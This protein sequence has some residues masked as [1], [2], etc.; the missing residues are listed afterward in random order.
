MAELCAL[1]RSQLL[2]SWVS[3]I[4]ECR[5]DPI[6]LT[7]A[8]LQ[9][10]MCVCKFTQGSFVLLDGLT[11]WPWENWGASQLGAF[12]PGPTSSQSSC[13]PHLPRNPAH[14]SAK[15]KAGVQGGKAEEICPEEKQ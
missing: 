14:L 9:E 3:S 13:Y 7:P 1:A 8:E 12:R 2:L 15:E 10:A 6:K 4:G 11:Y 5:S